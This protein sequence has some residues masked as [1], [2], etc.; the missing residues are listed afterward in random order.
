MGGQGSHRSLASEHTILVSCKGGGT[1]GD[2]VLLVVAGTQAEM[3][4]RRE[5]TL[6]LWVE[7]LNMFIKLDKFDNSRF[8]NNT[9]NELKSER[10][11]SPGCFSRALRITL[12]IPTKSP[13]LVLSVQ[14]ALFCMCVVLPQVISAA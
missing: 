3:R 1:A 7:K 5:H 6:K 13:G 10:V 14:Q 11:M 2:C 8:I 9:K 12:C 4:V